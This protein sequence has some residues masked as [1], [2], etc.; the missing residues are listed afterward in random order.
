[1]NARSIIE[2]QDKPA[3]NGEAGSL[4]KFIEKP[5]FKRELVWRNVILMLILHSSGFYAALLALK[6]RWATIWWAYALILMTSFGIQVEYKLGYK[7]NS[8]IRETRI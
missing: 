5:E 8:D 2:A 6:V 7:G 1:M 3:T 4:E